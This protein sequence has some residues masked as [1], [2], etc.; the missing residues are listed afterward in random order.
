VRRQAKHK[1]RILCENSEGNHPAVNLE[2]VIRKEARRHN[3]PA[4]Q[5]GHADYNGNTLPLD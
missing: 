2:V 5:R 1:K 3:G 4:K